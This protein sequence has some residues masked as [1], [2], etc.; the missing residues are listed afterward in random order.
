[1]SNDIVSVSLFSGAG[2]L[3]VAS[4]MAGVPVSVST[5]IEAD[6]VQT[7]RLNHEYFGQTEVI[8]G[9][10][11]QIDSSTF[12]DIVTRTGAKKFIVIGGAPCQPFS[13]AGYWVGHETR[14][15]IND[16]RATLVD[17]Y[18]RVVTDLQP[19]GFV[20]EN[21]ES[22]LHPTNKV[23]VDRFIEII[24]ESG[25][26]YTIVRANALEYGATLWLAHTVATADEARLAIKHGVTS[27][28]HLYNAMPPLH[29]RE[30]GPVAVALTGG[31][32]GEL[33]ADGMHICPDM[34]ALAYRCL[35]RDKTVLVTDSM[36][37]TGAPDGDYAIAG[38]PVVVKNGKALT[39]DGALA[40][41]TLNLWDGVKNLIQFASVPLCDAIACATINP[42]RMV[43]IDQTVGSIESG[44][45]ADLLLVDKA[46][47]L[48]TVLAN[49]VIQ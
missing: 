11:H 43:G 3:D 31:G 20:F 48:H 30:G 9:D 40:G 6:C 12:R 38:L 1:M 34:I 22:L 16:P 41:S 7:L 15:G 49:G 47:N 21:V 36:M 28:T 4:V 44:K 46:L 45:R 29:H 13:K 32:Y 37:A 25:Y 5:D 19:D 14:R 17:E 18:L 27:F 39:L 23:I 10:L 33:I 8:E 26:K 2:G 35:G 42:A 24:E